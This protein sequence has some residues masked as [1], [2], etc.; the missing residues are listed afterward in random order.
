MYIYIYIVYMNMYVYIYIYI[1]YMNKYI[2]VLKTLAVGIHTCVC[3]HEYIS[4]Y[5]YIYIYI[6]IGPQNVGRPGRRRPRILAAAGA[7]GDGGE[8]G[9][10]S[11][12]GDTSVAGRRR[13]GRGRG[14]NIH[15]Q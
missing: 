2:Q 14:V 3:T 13:G 15:R 8:R 4:I 10:V 9:G 12:L 5:L 1:V 11:K 7:R 6:Y